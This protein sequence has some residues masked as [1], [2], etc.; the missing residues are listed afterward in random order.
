MGF[1]RIDI[2]TKEFPPEI[3]GGAGVHVGHLVPALRELAGRVPV[4][5]RV[6]A[7]DDRFDTAV[8]GVAYFAVVEVLEGLVQIIRKFGKHP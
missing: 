5:V 2:V 6:H 3:Y 4:H 8:E 1:V 7:V